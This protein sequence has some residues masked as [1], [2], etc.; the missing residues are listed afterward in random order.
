MRY[1]L[2][3]H[4]LLWML[5]GD[6]RIGKETKELIMN[7]DN[8]IFYSAVSPWEIEIKHLKYPE[9]ITISGERFAGFCEQAG[10]IGLPVASKYVGEIKNIRQIDSNLKHNDP[11]D[12]MLLA[13]ARYE[14]MILITHDR[15]FRNY[16]DPHLLLC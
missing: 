11:F 10:F 13:Q 5:A 3:T 1:L 9:Q 7:P 15:K 2:D 6:E 16:D 12:M 14:N 4:I 8:Q